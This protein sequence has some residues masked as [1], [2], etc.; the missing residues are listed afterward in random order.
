MYFLNIWLAHGTQW[1]NSKR[2]LNLLLSMHGIIYI[3]VGIIMKNYGLNIIKRWK[4]YSS[5]HRDNVVNLKIGLW[6]NF[7]LSE[8]V[9]F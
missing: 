3:I 7:K 8:T 6:V 9:D 1:L 5:Y 4:T 2:A